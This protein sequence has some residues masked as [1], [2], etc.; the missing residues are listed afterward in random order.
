MPLVATPLGYRLSGEIKAMFDCNG[1]L[2]LSLKHAEVF[3]VEFMGIDGTTQIFTVP[4]EMCE[5]ERARLH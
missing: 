1:E 4:K 2:T 3:T 5:V